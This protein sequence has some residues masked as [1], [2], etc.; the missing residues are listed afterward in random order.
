[1]THST[2]CAPPFRRTLEDFE[3]TDRMRER[4]EERLEEHL[5]GIAQMWRDNGDDVDSDDGREALKIVRDTMRVPERPEW[6][7]PLHA[8]ATTA[9]IAGEPQTADE[10]LDLRDAMRTAWA[11]PEK[12]WRQMLADSMGLT[13]SQVQRYAPTTDLERE[14]RT[15]DLWSAKTAVYRRYD[16][17]GVLLYIGITSDFKGR[18]AV[19][20][21]LSPWWRHM[22]RTEA[23][24]FPDRES[25]LE[26]EANAIRAED[27]IFN[28]QHGRSDAH[29]RQTAY[30]DSTRVR[31]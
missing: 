5:I 31:A 22:A 14:R 9:G 30:F 25:A 16:A 12:E 10:H 2:V 24:W 3:V 19:H 11:F 13:Y 8:I 15:R 1:M 28:L 18:D 6:M 26:S 7:R 21:A 4:F 23:E 20:R 27:P 17:S 29:K